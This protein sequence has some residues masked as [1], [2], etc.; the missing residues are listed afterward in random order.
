MC[1]VQDLGQQNECRGTSEFPEAPG[2]SGGLE[3]RRRREMVTPWKIDWLTFSLK[4]WELKWMW[5]AGLLTSYAWVWHSCP[6][7]SKF[8][9]ILCAYN[10]GSCFLLSNSDFF[11]PLSSHV[12]QKVSQIVGHCTEWGAGRVYYLCQVLWHDA[13]MHLKIEN[14][15][16]KCSYVTSVGCSKPNVNSA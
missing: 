5:M 16:I 6:W 15:L 11:L 9:N 10:L 1:S 3:E 8:S 13:D 2:L 12:L 4:T 7:S 14:K